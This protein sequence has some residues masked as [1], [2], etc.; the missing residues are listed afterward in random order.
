[1]SF[2]TKDIM[3]EWKVLVSF[4]YISLI[5]T[6][7]FYL[8]GTDAL[9]I[10]YKL[11]VIVS[12]LIYSILIIN[13]YEKSKVI[14]EIIIVFA[15]EILGIAL[16]LIPTG[17]VESPFIW[18]ALNPIFM[19][20]VLL[21]GVYCW[22]V[23]IL[24]LAAA[25]TGSLI[26][27]NISVV[28]AWKQNHWVLLVF[29]LLTIFAYLLAKLIRQ[30]SKAYDE[31]SALYS[32]SKEVLQYNSNLYQALESL[33]S[34]EDSSHLAGL[35]VE[36]ARKLTGSPASVCYLNQSNIESRWIVSDPGGILINKFANKDN[37]DKIWDKL[38]ASTQDNISL[39]LPFSDKN[40]LIT[41]IAMQSIGTRFGFLGYIAPSGSTRDEYIKAVNFL[42]E[43]GAT[44]LERQKTD[45]LST[46]LMVSEEQNRIANEIHDGV[47]QYLF[48]IVYALHG[49]SKRK[50]AFQDEE[51]RNQLTLIANTASKAAQELRVSIYR[52]S[53]RRRGEQVFVA[54]ISSYLAELAKLNNVKVDINAEG[55][56]E[57]ISPA[58]RKA[59]YRIIRESTSNAI[60]HGM[61]RNI[62][63]RLQMEPSMVML[64]IT[65]DGKG[66][67]VLNE[68]NKGLGLENMN[69][70]VTSFKGRLN[71]ESSPGQGTKITF[72][73]PDNES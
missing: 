32:A 49:L 35:L 66:F 62:K 29:L 73:I 48:S 15:A 43:L 6:S 40:E 63:V 71:I 16:F 20:T 52:I 67:D 55:S 22:G 4:R 58:L 39:A 28:D 18:Y 31:L 44:V 11:I 65:D 51:T 38:S 57:A 34:G 68:K 30:L 50:G 21:P 60:R 12:L 56:E 27:K 19:S 23:L 7:T 1:M 5:L 61:S 26:L 53:P 54:G 47:S 3:N 37:L 24:F 45:E 25:T 42:A 70:L 33:S 9:L 17:G 46:R 69:S 64:Q 36:Y 72:L 2:S 14:F 41:C 8:L 13:L 10:R 59:L